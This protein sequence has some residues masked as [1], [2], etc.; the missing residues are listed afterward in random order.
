MVW[1]NVPTS[2]NGA[3]IETLEK[4]A[5]AVGIP[6]NL[7]D[8]FCHCNSPNFIGYPAI[9]QLNWP[10]WLHNKSIMDR[11]KSLTP[12]GTYC[13]NCMLPSK[14]WITYNAMRICESCESYYLP[15]IQ[16]YPIK[17][18]LCEK[19]DVPSLLKSSKKRRIIHVHTTNK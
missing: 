18:F 12:L 3:S 19:C 10:V 4:W 16:D 6:M 14:P 5:I 7:Q 2:P 9:H 11:V 17:T 15:K 1:P 8:K 13:T